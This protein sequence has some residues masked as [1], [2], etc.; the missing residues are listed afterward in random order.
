MPAIVAGARAVEAILAK[1]E[2]VYGDQHRL[3]QLASIRIRADGPGHA[4]AQHRVVAR[5]RRRRADA[6][7][8]RAAHAGIEAGQPGAGR[9][10][11]AAGDGAVPGCNVVARSDARGAAQGSV[12]A[13]GDLAP[14]AHMAAAM[15]GVGEVMQA[16][17]HVPAAEALAR[18]GMT[19]LVL[20]AKEG[21]ALLN[22]TQF[23]TAYALAGLF[24]AETLLRAGARRPAR[25]RPMPR[26]GP[27]RRS[28]RASTRCAAIAGRSTLPR[29][30]RALLA[31]SAIRASHLTGDDRVQDPYCLRC[32]PQ[33]MGAVPRYSSPRGGDAA[34]RSQRRIRQSAD[35]RR[36]GRSAVGR[37]FPR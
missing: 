20:G 13:S 1:G 6:G 35:L 9:F 30:L 29:A 22:G 37:Q 23:S 15:I 12:G 31:G 2:P 5:G 32:Q 8:A 4:P 17:E 24:E 21:L 26:A 3:R 7:A 27:M 25:C 10:G 18:A 36:S 14:L 16:G 19:P 11:R 33:V 34:D 28:I